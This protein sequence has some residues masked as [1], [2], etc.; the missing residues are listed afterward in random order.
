MGPAPHAV[1]GHHAPAPRPAL[2]QIGSALLQQEKDALRRLGE[3]RGT[4][5][6]IEWYSLQTLNDQGL[7]TGLAFGA[8]DGIR[9]QADSETRGDLSAAIGA[10]LRDIEEAEEK[11]IQNPKLDP[12]REKLELSEFQCELGQELIPKKYLVHIRGYNYDVRYLVKYM[13]TSETPLDMYQKTVFSSEEYEKICN[14]LKIPVPE[15]M[16]FWKINSEE[17]GKKYQMKLKESD[18]AIY[19]DRRYRNLQQS[20]NS[21]GADRILRE[22]TTQY[23]PPDYKSFLSDNRWYEFGRMIRLKNDPNLIDDFR[24]IIKIPSIQR[25]QHLG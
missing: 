3:G 2:A 13:L 23:A 12:N 20:G 24:D 11:E 10:S 16:N 5:R 9:R 17:S 21:A 19:N 18:R 15:F 4:P 22:I 25:I 7:S 14:A 8:G 1:F 6:D